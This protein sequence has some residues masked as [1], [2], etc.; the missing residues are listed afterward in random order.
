MLYILDEGKGRKAE[1]RKGWQK[2]NKFVCSQSGVKSWPSIEFKVFGGVSS[3]S[4]W[5][6]L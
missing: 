3:P 5:G 2:K 4:P 1:K 6:V